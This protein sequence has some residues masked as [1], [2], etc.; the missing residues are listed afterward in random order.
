MSNLYQSHPKDLKLQKQEDAES[1][2]SNETMDTEDDEP[3]DI[4][5]RNPQ[6]PNRKPKADKAEKSHNVKEGF[7]GDSKKKKK[8]GPS[9]TEKIKES[10]EET[11]NNFFVDFL[12]APNTN[13]MSLTQRAKVAAKLFIKRI[14]MILFLLM[15]GINI[16][17]A[18]NQYANEQYFPTDIT[19]PPYYPTPEEKKNYED[20]TKLTDK[21]ETSVKDFRRPSQSY[22]TYLY[23]RGMDL[24]NPKN[25]CSLQGARTDGWFERSWIQIIAL[26]ELIKGAVNSMINT[27][28]ALFNR[29]FKGLEDEVVEPEK[30]IAEEIAEE[31]EKTL[32]DYQKGKEQIQEQKLQ[33]E[34]NIATQRRKQQANIAGNEMKEEAKD[35]VPVPNVS[36]RRNISGSYGNQNTSRA[37]SVFQR[38][39]PISGQSQTGRGK[40]YSQKAG[41][42]SAQRY[43][44]FKPPDHSYT[45]G[46]LG[47]PNPYAAD[48]QREYTNLFYPFWPSFAYGARMTAVLINKIYLLFL[49]IFK[50]KGEDS[51][52][53][54]TSQ[55]SLIQTFRIFGLLLYSL[56][57]SLG[58]IALG[59]LIITITPLLAMIIT[60]I[61]TNIGFLGFFSPQFLF[62]ALYIFLLF[63]TIFAII[64]WRTLYFHIF[65]FLA[66]LFSMDET[67]KELL[68]SFIKDRTGFF[69]L[70]WAIFTL[71]VYQAAPE[72]LQSRILLYFTIIPLISGVAIRRPNIMGAS[73]NSNQSNAK[74]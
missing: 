12:I 28:T 50:S 61:A 14:F 20:H 72:N 26:I 13:G 62:V 55:E 36:E 16:E 8:K 11:G 17:R 6:S 34:A 60:V 5:S 63:C 18:A 66:P 37:N 71:S 58:S 43:A 10:T 69:I 46:Y 47:G 48:K 29:F 19:K 44:F 25:P 59:S 4:K 32:L 68:R 52:N 2:S 7:T 45:E 40:P 70:S 56:M 31:A 73:P 22:P 49:M 30:E 74:Q 41:D 3:V 1:I 53:T 65:V 27:V 64:W 54:P 51:Q 67:L 23:Y 57:G 39:Q 33:K 35:K 24:P 15:F 9:D 38:A 42:K 21:C